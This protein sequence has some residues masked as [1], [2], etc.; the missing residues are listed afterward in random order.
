MDLISL[1]WLIIAIPLVSAGVLL[2]GGERT[3]AWGH[4]LG[5]VAS[6]ASGL[7]SIGLLFTLLGMPAAERVA[8]QHLYDWIVSDSFNVS[9]GLLI[10]PLSVAFM[11]LITFVGTLIHVYS[12]A[13]MEGDPDRRRFFAYLNLFIASMLILVM[14]DS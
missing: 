6:A 3:N 14:A 7:L 10:D 12:V 4:W 13:Y 9:A 5:V 11:L 8:N 2:V 1:S